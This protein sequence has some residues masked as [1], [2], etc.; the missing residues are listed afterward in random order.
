MHNSSASA[1]VVLLPL[2][3]RLRDCPN[4]LGMDRNR[5]NREVRPFLMEIPIGS[6]GIAFYRLEIDNWACQYMSRNGRRRS[7]LERK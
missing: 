1:Q 4:Y 3:I 2:F 6:Q 7:N 5:F